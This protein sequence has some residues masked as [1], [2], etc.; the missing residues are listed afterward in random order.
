MSDALLPGST[1]IWKVVSTPGCSPSR[2]LY[3]KEWVFNRFWE[4]AKKLEKEWKSGFGTPHTIVGYKLE[5][6]NGALA[7][8]EIFRIN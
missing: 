4:T 3:D 1:D 6:E 2:S 8:K 7:W 5:I